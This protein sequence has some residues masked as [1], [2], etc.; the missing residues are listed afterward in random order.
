M[1]LG[2]VRLGVEQFLWRRMRRVKTAVKAQ[3]KM[4]KYIN[5]QQ[6]TRHPN[7]QAS[8]ACV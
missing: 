6:R 7:G 2:E 5:E 8:Q 1:I 4:T 3:E